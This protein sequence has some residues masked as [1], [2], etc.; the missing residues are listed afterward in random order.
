M[1]GFPHIR[2]SFGDGNT[3][4]AENPTYTYTTAGTFTVTLTVT[5]D[6][7]A[8]DSDTSSASINVA[9]NN[10]PVADPNGPYGGTVG[11]TL[12][13]DGTGSTDSDGSIVAHIQSARRVC[14][15]TPNCSS[16][17]T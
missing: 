10:L 15:W 5:D 12:T 1:H 9:T 3:S 2:G 4:T 11:T 6:N 17:F 14:A 16:P 7:G 8:S 13:F